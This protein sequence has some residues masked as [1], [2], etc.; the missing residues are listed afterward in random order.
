MR[1]EFT[2]LRPSM[3]RGVGSANLRASPLR[4]MAAGFPR[5]LAS[6]ATPRALATRSAAL[7]SSARSSSQPDAPSSE[8]AREAGFDARADALLARIE[9]ALDLSEIQA[10]EISLAMG[11]LTIALG[12]KGTWVLNKQKPNAQV[13]WSSPL[14]G[15]KRFAF[16][17]GEWVSTRDSGTTLVGLLSSEL[18]KATG[19]VIKM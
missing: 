3:G 13:W 19:T 11:V 6:A 2:R 1:V 9:H 10:E 14:S 17:N 7:S 4:F 16:E 5:A 12:D 8:G 15:P 18:E